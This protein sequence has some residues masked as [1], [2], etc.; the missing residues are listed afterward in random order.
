MVDGINLLEQTESPEEVRYVADVL[1]GFA[2][3]M[4]NGRTVK[5]CMSS[6]DFSTAIRGSF[7]LDDEVSV[8]AQ[9]S[10]RVQD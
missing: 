7:R 2:T 9:E 5:L 3:E 10:L 8:D 1:C 6:L 4:A